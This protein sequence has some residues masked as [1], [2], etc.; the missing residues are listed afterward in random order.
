MI[1]PD[2]TYAHGPGNGA[3][4][5][6]DV[7]SAAPA[8]PAMRV[9]NGAASEV[10]RLRTEIDELQVRLAR[11]EARL[12]KVEGRLQRVLGS[13]SYRFARRLATVR[14]RVASLVGVGSSQ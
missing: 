6:Q 13:R 8:V 1:E 14:R 4:T 5:W 11:S 2:P 9:G 7:A 10:S 12:V 3:D